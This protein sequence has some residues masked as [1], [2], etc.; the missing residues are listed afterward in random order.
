MKLDYRQRLFLY[1]GLLFTFFTAG[2]IVFEQVRERN[3]KTQALIERLENYTDIIQVAIA[4]NQDSVAST[5][6]QLQKLLPNELRIT[7]IDKEGKYCMIILLMTIVILPI[8]KTDR[9]S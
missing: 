1:F 4:D 9:K 6:N 2:I 5:I 3:Y 8:I 7:I